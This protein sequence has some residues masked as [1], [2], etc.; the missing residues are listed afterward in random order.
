MDNINNIKKIDKGLE[1]HTRG[2][3]WFDL[4]HFDLLQ[5]PRA[6]P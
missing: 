5:S 3:S 6:F 2:L 1:D 4:N